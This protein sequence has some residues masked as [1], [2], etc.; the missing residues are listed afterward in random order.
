MIELLLEVLRQ[1][2]QS[3]PAMQA[4]VSVHGARVM[5][6]FDTQAAEQLVERGISLAQSLSPDERSPILEEFPSVI[7]GTDPNRAVGLF[8]SLEKGERGSDPDRLLFAMLAHGHV[9]EAV[10]HLSSS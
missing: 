9:A 3:A 7:A 10:E 6:K 2:E 5:S 4:A 1:A 8:M